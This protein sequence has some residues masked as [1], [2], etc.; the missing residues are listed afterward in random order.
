MT[1]PVPK[2][3]W[4]LDMTSGTVAAE[5]YGGARIA[6]DRASWVPGRQGQA[7]RFHPKNGAR[8]ATTNVRDLPAPWTIAAWVMREEDSEAATLVSS[9]NQMIRLEQ[10]P[11]LHHVGLTHAGVF[12]ATFDRA[13]PLHQ[14]VHLA[15]VGTAAGVTLYVNGKR[16]GEVGAPTVLGLRWLGSFGG[17]TDFASVIIDE[18]TIFDQVL[19]DDQVN[20]L[21]NQNTKLPAPDTIFPLEGAWSCTWNGTKHWTF[22]L[23][24]SGHTLT[25]DYGDY[26]PGKIMSGAILSPAKICNLNP[27]GP[28]DYG[29]LSGNPDTIYWTS[30]DGT[31]LMVWTRAQ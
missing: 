30:H 23:K 27:S 16:Q 18:L 2:H 7:I 25:I 19:T 12:D 31:P 9:H 5:P 26:S 11:S 4:K 28:A 20:E 13:I 29:L 15:L 6:L 1:I 21:A 22:G 14:W 10:W 24:V 17:W 8:L 3:Y